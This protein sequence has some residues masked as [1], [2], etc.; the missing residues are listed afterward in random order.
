MTVSSVST[1]AFAFKWCM[2]CM[3][4]PFIEAAAAF[5]TAT[6]LAGTGLS[7]TFLSVA[8]AWQTHAESEAWSF[9][10][11]AECT[12][13]TGFYSDELGNDC[14][15]RCFKGYEAGHIRA[16]STAVQDIMYVGICICDADYTGTSC[17]ETCSTTQPHQHCLVGEHRAE[18]VEVLSDTQ[19]VCKA[20]PQQAPLQVHQVVEL[21]L[22]KSPDAA[23]NKLPE[24]TSSGVTIQVV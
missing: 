23:G 18:L 20:P 6:N 15:S 14:G 3:E 21:S 19:A 2:N 7:V 13:D 11:P 9:T 22:T 12:C 24:Y 10:V 8:G 17:T 16:L 4:G 5:G 1:N